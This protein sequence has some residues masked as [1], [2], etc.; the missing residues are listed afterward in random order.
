MESQIINIIEIFKKEK[1]YHNDIK[2][3]NFTVKSGKIYIID[4]GLASQYSPSY[5]Y[6]NIYLETIQKSTTIK[7]M[8]HHIANHSSN[9][10]ITMCNILN[11]Y[12]NN[13]LRSQ[14]L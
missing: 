3:E 7:E 8:F 11:Q 6:L 1:I 12:I 14:L 9:I 10:T 4:F 5:S 13:N 2:I